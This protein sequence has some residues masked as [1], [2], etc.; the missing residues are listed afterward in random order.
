MSMIGK[1]VGYGT[2]TSVTPGDEVICSGST[3][4]QCDIA[5]TATA[6]FQVKGPDTEWRA[7]ADGAVTL[8]GSGMWFIDLPKSVR[9]RLNV[10]A[11]TS[12]DV[13]WNIVSNPMHNT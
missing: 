7:L 3:M 6:A 9:C 1:H 11:W 10:S 4:F 5:G 8:S 13:D 12:G 2:I